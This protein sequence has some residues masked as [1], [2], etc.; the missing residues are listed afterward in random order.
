M[1]YIVLALTL[2]L[3]ASQAAAFILVPQNPAR[4]V[5][6]TLPKTICLKGLVYDELEDSCVQSLPGS[7]HD[8][9][10]FE[11]PNP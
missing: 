8:D 2:S 7:L 1:K 10:A 6:E 3:S 5:L 11:T 4:V 9:E